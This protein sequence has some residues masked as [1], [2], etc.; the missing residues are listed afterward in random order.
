M[1]AK[2][3]MSTKLGVIDTFVIILLCI[4]SCATPQLRY[5]LVSHDRQFA[6]LLITNTT[7]EHIDWFEMCVLYENPS[8]LIHASN[9]FVK[10]TINIRLDRLCYIIN[11]PLEP[12]ES[13]EVVIARDEGAL[14]DLQHLGK[15]MNSV[16]FEPTRINTLWGLPPLEDYG[17]GKPPNKD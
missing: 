17:K 5:N 16:V 4:T 9:Y 11:K 2:R 3:F 14:A 6:E 12:G 8:G 10:P 1:L 15:V 13:I 7:S